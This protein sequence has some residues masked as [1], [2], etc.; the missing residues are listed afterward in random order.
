MMLDSKKMG[1]DKAMRKIPVMEIIE[2]A[3]EKLVS[4][5]K[6]G[7]PFVVCMSNSATDFATTFNDDVLPTGEVKEGTAYF[8]K[9]VFVNGGVNLLGDEWMKKIFREKELEH[10]FAMSRSPD[11]FQVLITSKFSDEDYEEFLF[12][13]GYGLHKPMSQYQVFSIKK[14]SKKE[15]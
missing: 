2:D 5:I 4:A 13:D 6:L 10:G 15:D 3:R 9:E 12:P 11:E 7:L 1:L 8:P 14:E